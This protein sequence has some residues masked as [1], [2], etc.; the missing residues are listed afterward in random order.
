M[1]GGVGLAAHASHRVVTERTRLAMPE[2]E[3]VFFP[4]VGGTCSIPIARGD[5][6][7]FGLTGKP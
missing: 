6:H 2:S 4:D 7:Y 3:S 1:G 5:R